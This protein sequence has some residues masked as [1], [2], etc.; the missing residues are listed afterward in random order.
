MVVEVDVMVEVE[1]M[2]VVAVK[3]LVLWKLKMI[4]EETNWIKL[5]KDVEMESMVHSM[6][7]VLVAELIIVDYLGHWHCLPGLYMDCLMVIV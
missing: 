2:I 3:M 6:V 4:G 7:T 1:I 5:D